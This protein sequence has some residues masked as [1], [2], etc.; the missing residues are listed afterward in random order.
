ML[1]E[2]M[3]AELML[4]ELTRCLSS[5]YSAFEGGGCNVISEGESLRFMEFEN[6]FLSDGFCDISGAC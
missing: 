6:L 3:L 4:T 5:L 2:L 1:P